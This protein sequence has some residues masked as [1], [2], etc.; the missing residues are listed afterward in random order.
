MGDDM[1]RRNYDGTMSNSETRSDRY[2]QIQLITYTPRTC[3]MIS[4]PFPG[5]IFLSFYFTWC[6][7]RMHDDL[8]VGVR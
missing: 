5:H 7:R 4:L 1:P 8:S 2:V 3:L 6:A